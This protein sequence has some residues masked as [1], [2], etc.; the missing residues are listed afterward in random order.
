MKYIEIDFE[1]DVIRV[2]RPLN[3]NPTNYL[4]Y[5]IYELNTKR[6]KTIQ[7]SNLLFVPLKTR[8]IYV[9]WLG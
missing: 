2:Y 4:S 8:D 6:I 1:R 5:K 7:N 9:V 3:I